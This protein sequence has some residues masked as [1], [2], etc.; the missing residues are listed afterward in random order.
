MTPDEI[1]SNIQPTTV[2]ETLLQEI[3]A[4]LASLNQFFYSTTDELNGGQT[5]GITVVLSTSCGDSFPVVTRT[6]EEEKERIWEEE[7]S[8]RKRSVMGTVSQT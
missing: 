1:R 7:N 3:A 8:S 2:T 6:P 5:P 4:Q